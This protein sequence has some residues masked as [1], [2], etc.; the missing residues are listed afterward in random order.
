M[1]GFLATP[2]LNTISRVAESEADI[3]GLNAAREPQGF[4]S[5]ALRLATYRKLDPGPLDAITDIAGIMVGHV[6]KIEGDSGPLVP[7]K[8]PVRTGVTV[9]IPNSEIW[10]RRVAAAKLRNTKRISSPL[11]RRRA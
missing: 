4:A 1:L 7:G 10:M 6:T 9:V 2:A 8:G 11:R 3:F 5:V